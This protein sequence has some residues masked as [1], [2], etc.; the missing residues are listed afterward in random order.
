MTVEEITQLVEDIR[1]A[2]SKLKSVQKVFMFDA[3]D[4]NPCFIIGNESGGDKI[5]LSGNSANE[6]KRM[7]L[8]HHG[9]A[10]RRLKDKL[11]DGLNL[12]E[13]RRV[14]LLKTLK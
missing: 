11:R 4:D 3:D 12:E 6:F 8:T 7:L 13:E 10:I 1:L 2:H 5:K 9:K 14:K